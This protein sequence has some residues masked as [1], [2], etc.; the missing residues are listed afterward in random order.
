MPKNEVHCALSMKRTGKSYKQLHKWIDDNKENR[1]VDHRNKKHSYSKDLRDFIF[2]KYGGSEAV[3]E[4]LFHIALDYLD[5]CTINEWNHK[6]ED[7]NFYRFGFKCNG[8]IFYDE[9]NLG[10]EE[11]KEKFKG[12][13]IIGFLG[14][15]KELFG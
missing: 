3:G 12:T 2:K 5:T 8:F 13:M 6:K 15:L 4:W 14:K 7:I 11:L 1:G 9:D 10:D